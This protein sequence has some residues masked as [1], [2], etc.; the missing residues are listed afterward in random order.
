[1][2]DCLT[3][4]ELRACAIC[5]LSGLAN[6]KCSG[7]CDCSLQSARTAAANTIRAVRVFQRPSKRALFRQLNSRTTKPLGEILKLH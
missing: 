6:G 3:E 5:H 1:M 7:L 4:W 2:E